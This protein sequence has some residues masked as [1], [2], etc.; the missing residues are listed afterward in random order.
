MAGGRVLDQKNSAV[1]QDRKQES[2]SCSRADTK[3]GARP[4]YRSGNHGV[5]KEETYCIYFPFIKIPT[6]Q[7]KRTNKN[8]AVF[9]YL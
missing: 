6:R 9:C 3:E 4:G 8:R 5:R 1:L 2:S 7:L